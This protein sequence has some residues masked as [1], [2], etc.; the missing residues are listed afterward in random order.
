[1]FLNMAMFFCTKEAMYKVLLVNVYNWINYFWYNRL[2]ITYSGTKQEIIVPV[3]KIDWIDR[4]L[5]CFVIIQKLKLRGFG[6]IIM[7]QDH[8][9]NLI[10]DLIQNEGLNIHKR[11]GEHMY[12]DII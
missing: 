10:F 5:R 3:N 1:M 6:H 7:M 12:T 4:L 2:L 8:I 9:S 11:I